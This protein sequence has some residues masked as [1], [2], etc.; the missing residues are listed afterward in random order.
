MKVQPIEWIVCALITGIV[1]KKWRGRCGG[2]HFGIIFG[3]CSKIYLYTRPTNAGE[4][5]MISR[6]VILIIIHNYPSSIDEI[7]SQNVSS[8]VLFTSNKHILIKD[9]V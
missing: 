4:R 5:C 3:C 6:G 2:Y 7:C 8:Y 9:F 1:G